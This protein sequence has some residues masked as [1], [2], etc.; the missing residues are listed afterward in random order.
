[1]REHG[2]RPGVD[3]GRRSYRGAV[4]PDRHTNL[5]NWRRLARCQGDLAAD[6]YPPFAGE[7][8]RERLAREQRAKDVCA[9]C[10]VRRPCLDQAVASGER[11]GVWGGLSADE[12]LTFRRSA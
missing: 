6:F 8:K 9:G 10:P 4:A 11:Y 7:R 5:T 12:R 2:P 1:M 3:G